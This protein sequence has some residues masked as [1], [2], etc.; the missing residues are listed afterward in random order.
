MTLHDDPRADPFLNREPEADGARFTHLFRDVTTFQ[1]I[2]ETWR[3]V[4]TT[5]RWA[6][7]DELL[8]AAVARS[9]ALRAEGAEITPSTDDVWEEWGLPQN[10][11]ELIAYLNWMLE[12]DFFVPREM[13]E[14]FHHHAELRRS[15]LLAAGVVTGPSPF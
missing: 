3:S 12:A 11:V 15:Q 6:D 8:E 1:G 13:E 9:R 7:A 14:A 4:D 2:D 5:E 10:D